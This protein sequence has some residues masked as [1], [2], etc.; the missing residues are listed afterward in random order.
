M[1]DPLWEA[2]GGERSARDIWAQRPHGSNRRASV[3]SRP[4]SKAVSGDVPLRTLA[5]HVEELTLM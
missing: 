5:K 1:L 2:G 4:P 3:R